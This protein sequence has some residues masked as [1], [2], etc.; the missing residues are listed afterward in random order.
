MKMVAVAA[1]FER[2][3]GLAFIYLWC[4]AVTTIFCLATRE[5]WMASPPTLDLE[6]PRPAFRKNSVSLRACRALVI[7]AARE[8]I[9]PNERL[10]GD[11]LRTIA[12]ALVASAR[13]T[14]APLL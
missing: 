4:A 12:T 6:T 7:F 1:L 8:R 10:S 11:R 5:T 9:R 3:G 13:Q 2:S 14:P